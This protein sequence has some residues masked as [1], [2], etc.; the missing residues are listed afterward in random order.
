LELVGQQTS[1]QEQ[2][3]VTIAMMVFVI[4]I[5]VVDSCWPLRLGQILPYGLTR[6]GHHLCF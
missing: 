6:P 5:E 3:A 4:M 2:Y 1:V